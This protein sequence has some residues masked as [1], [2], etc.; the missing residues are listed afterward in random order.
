MFS[1]VPVLAEVYLAVVPPQDQF[2]PNT[3][4]CHGEVFFGVG[5]KQARFVSV[6]VYMHQYVAVSILMVVLERRTEHSVAS[7]I[8]DVEHILIV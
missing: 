3:S 6:T 4:S 8:L 2:D 1:E 5:Y 7:I